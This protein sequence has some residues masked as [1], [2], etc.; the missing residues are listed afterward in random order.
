MHTP[1]L[2]VSSVSSRMAWYL[3][4]VKAMCGCHTIAQGKG[5]HTLFSTRPVCFQSFIRELSAWA[6]VHMKVRRNSVE[7]GFCLPVGL[8]Y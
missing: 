6:T 3:I 5:Q 1:L 2:H 8:G 4:Q 7:L